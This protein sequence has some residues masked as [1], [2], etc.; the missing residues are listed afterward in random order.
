MLPRILP[1]EAKDCERQNFYFF[2]NSPVMA[3]WMRFKASPFS[4]SVYICPFKL[5][6]GLAMGNLGV[7]ESLQLLQWEEPECPLPLDLYQLIRAVNVFSRQ[8]F[9]PCAL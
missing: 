6:N 4:S 1:D 7:T 9:R 8:R 2:T 5:K 3:K